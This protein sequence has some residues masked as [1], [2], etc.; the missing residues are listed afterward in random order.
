MPDEVKA[1]SLW[2]LSLYMNNQICIQDQSQSL[3]SEYP[4]ENILVGWYDATMSTNNSLSN[5]NDVNSHRGEEKKWL[6]SFLR[7]YFVRQIIDL[8]RAFS[9]V[10]AKHMKCWFFP[11]LKSLTKE[12]L[13]VSEVTFKGACFSCQGLCDGEELDLQRQLPELWYVKTSCVGSVS[14]L[15]DWG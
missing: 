2:S 6:Q 5:S 13:L 1:A 7:S 11:I 12:D 14:C 8:Y 3:C 4:C 10:L 9:G 15:I